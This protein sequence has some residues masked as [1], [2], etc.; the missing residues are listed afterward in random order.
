MDALRKLKSRLFLKSLRGILSIIICYSKD[1][2]I[3]YVDYSKGQNMVLLLFIRALFLLT[4][5]AF[6]VVGINK[7]STKTED[8]WVFIAGLVVTILT[9]VVEWLTPKKKL[10]ALAG[11]F[12]GLLVGMLISWA[13][14]QI[15]EMLDLVFFQLEPATLEMVT[16]LMG[17]CICYLTISLVIRTKDD[18]RFVIPYVEFSR[19]TKGLRPLVLDTS[20]IIDGRIADIAETI[21]DKVENGSFDSV[22]KFD[23]GDDGVVVIDHQTVG[24]EDQPADCTIQVTL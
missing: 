10:S 4:A 3:N 21:R 17:V 9:I 12:F 16:W 20:V 7:T 13:M 5:T 22:V 8:I 18:V 14:S 6:L 2:Y 23:C 15:L 19:Q 1:F 24:I 11:I